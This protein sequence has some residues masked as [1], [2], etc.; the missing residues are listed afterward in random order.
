MADLSKYSTFHIKRTT[1]VSREWTSALKVKGIA[2]LFGAL[3]QGGDDTI[4]IASEEVEILAPASDSSQ[5]TKWSL[6]GCYSGQ[7]RN[8]VS[9]AIDL[10]DIAVDLVSTLDDYFVGLTE[11]RICPPGSPEPIT[12]V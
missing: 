2:S 8:V 6:W 5:S 9:N 4:S 1:G 3:L 11:I 12:L 10:D 7:W